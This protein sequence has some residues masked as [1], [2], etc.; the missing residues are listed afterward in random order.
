MRTIEEQ[1]GKELPFVI[2]VCDRFTLDSQLFKIDEGTLAKVYLEG[3]NGDS[4]GAERKAQHDYGIAKLLYDKGVSVPKPE[5]V[6]IVPIEMG[7]DKRCPSFVMEYVQ[8]Y[9]LRELEGTEFRHR[10]DGLAQRAKDEIGKAE[11]LGFTPKDLCGGILWNPQ[12]DKVY[13]ID[14]TQWKSGES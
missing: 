4:A 2:K 6:F 13:L 10:V 3:I 1:R 5:G 11:R 7:S 12:N 14:F 8:G 9:T